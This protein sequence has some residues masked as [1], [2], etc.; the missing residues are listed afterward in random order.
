MVGIVSDRRLSFSRVLR[1]LRVCYG[2]PRPPV[3]TDPFQLILWEQVAYLAPDERRQEAFVALR[4]R[5]GLAPAGIA[6]APAATLAA[7]ARIGGAIAAGSRAGRMRRSAQM[8]LARWH[9]DLRGA[10]ALPTEKARRALAA[11]PMIGEPGADKILVFA[12]TAPLVPLDSNGLRVLQRLG[13][14][15]ASADYRRDYR[16]ARE[17]LAAQAPRTRR[18]RIAAYFLLREHGQRT[19]R[20]S[21]PQCALCPLQRGCPTGRAARRGEAPSVA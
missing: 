7:V 4:T 19:C 21:V 6:A 16:A 12:G 5:V 13:M 10:L 1:A 18:A 9:G 11:F 3:S 2:E 14:A 15:P 20:R 17:A 8:V